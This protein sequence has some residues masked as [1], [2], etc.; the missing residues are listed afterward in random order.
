[1]TPLTDAQRLIVLEYVPQVKKY[2]ARRYPTVTNRTD[3]MEANA[4]LAICEAVASWHGG[5]G[6]E[7]DRHVWKSIRADWR[8]AWRDEREHQHAEYPDDL[9]SNAPEPGDDP[10]TADCEREEQANTLIIQET[11]ALPFDDKIALTMKSFGYKTED[12]ASELNQPA[13]TVRYRIQK[14]REAFEKLFSEKS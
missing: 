3:T 6:E 1:M 4:F 5:P 11:A 8:D 12:I 7:R 13:C 10:P 2:I 9:A 14:V